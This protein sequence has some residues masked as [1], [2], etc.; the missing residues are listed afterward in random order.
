VDA[1]IEARIAN[2]DAGSS[3]QSLGDAAA[4]VIDKVRP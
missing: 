3:W 2:R 4:R 1:W